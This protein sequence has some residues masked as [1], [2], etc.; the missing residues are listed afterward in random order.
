MRVQNWRSESREA[1]VGGVG[2]GVGGGRV[3]AWQQ[4]AGAECRRW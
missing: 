3:S 4:E 1:N 2:D